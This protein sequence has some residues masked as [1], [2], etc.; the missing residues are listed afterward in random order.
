MGLT[1]HI[2]HHVCM[3]LL[4]HKG[5]VATYN[6]NVYNVKSKL[7]GTCKKI[8]QNTQNTQMYT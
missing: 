1:V 2:A 8:K 3:H 6:A 7:Y 5:Q 4:K